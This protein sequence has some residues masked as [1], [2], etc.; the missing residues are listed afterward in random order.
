[1][2]GPIP[3]AVIACMSHIVLLCNVQY[4]YYI[5]ARNKVSCLMQ[6]AIRSTV[7]IIKAPGPCLHGGA[8]GTNRELT[9]SQT[10][11][12]KNTMLF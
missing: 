12:Y 4:E 6:D 11:E 5:H 8:G 1:M 10:Y 9:L 3:T 7:I 2:V